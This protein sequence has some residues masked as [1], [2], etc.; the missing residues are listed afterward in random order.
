MFYQSKSTRFYYISKDSIEIV[1][2]ELEKF[3]SRKEFSTIN[4]DILKTKTD[5]KLSEKEPETLKRAFLTNSLT[6]NQREEAK[7]RLNK[8]KKSKY[9]SNLH[10]YEE[11]YHIPTPNNQDIEIESDLLLK[12]RKMTKCL[13][14]MCKSFSKYNSR[15]QK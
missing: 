11:L 13:K 8:A 3:N 2:Q 1:D 5:P 9:K 14:R 10:V 12:Q 6:Y 7:E 15:I 4:S